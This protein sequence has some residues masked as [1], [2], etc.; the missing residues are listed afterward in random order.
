MDLS[1]DISA[2]GKRPVLTTR[3]TYHEELESLEQQVLEMGRLCG[4]M[5]SDAVEAL[6]QSDTSLAE[7]VL[8]NDDAVDQADMD[9]EMQCMRLF[10]LQ[11]PMARDLRQIGTALKVITDLERV[12]DHAVDIAKIGRKLTQQLFVRQPLVDIGPHAEMAQKML[13]Q[14]LESLV[15]HDLKLAAQICADDDL[16]DEEFKRLREELIGLTQKD[17]S[18]TAAATYMLLAVVYLERIADHATNIAERVHYV[19][20]GQLLQ[21]SREHRLG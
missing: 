18:L 13:Y 6:Q 16:V 4:T 14:S 12:G 3:K 11:Q 7:T 21:L 8:V 2:L 9:I 1:A 5:V 15:R 19:E 20:T 10:A 17:A